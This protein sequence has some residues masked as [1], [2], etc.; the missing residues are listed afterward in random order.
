MPQKK[1]LSE[2]QEA[3]Q[4]LITRTPVADQKQLVVLLKKQYGI[5]TNQAV[6][7][8]DL[9]KLGAIKKMINGNLVYEMPDINVSAEISRLALVDINFNESMIVVKTHP[10]LAAFVGDQIDQ[11]KDLPIL[12]SLAGENVVFIVPKSIKNI[13][14]IYEAICEK[15][16][17]K[18]AV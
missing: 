7:S 8:R 2:R 3:I 4:E 1:E 5:D 18:K 14:A 6:V 9:R 11:H 15:L 10:G 13:K 17:F 12:G 16:H